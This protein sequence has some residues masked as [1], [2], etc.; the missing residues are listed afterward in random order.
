MF[1]FPN[2]SRLSWG[3]ITMRYSISSS[4]T[5]ISRFRILGVTLIVVLLMVSWKVSAEIIWAPTEAWTKAIQAYDQ[6][7]NSSVPKDIKE[8]LTNQFQEFEAFEQSMKDGTCPLCLESKSLDDEIKIH[9]DEVSNW[10]SQ[11][12]NFNASC[13]IVSSEEELAACR[14][15]RSELVNW[16]DRLNTEKQELDRR[17]AEIEEKLRISNET[18]DAKYLQ[19]AENVQEEFSKFSEKAYLLVNALDQAGKFVIE[20]YPNDE[21]HRC[22]LFFHKVLE[23]RGATEPG[24]K[25]DAAA[26]IY[27]ALT[28]NQSSDWETMGEDEVQEAANRGEIVVGV[29]SGHVAIAAPVPLSTDFSKFGGHSGPDIMV[30]DGNR[31]T[32]TS[33]QG[34]KGYKY[35]K[36]LGTVKV[37]YAFRNETPKWFIYVGSLK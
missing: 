13:A 37:A 26:A 4:R 9:E 12:A 10:D 30:R 23:L 20:Q 19:Y 18:K 32:G 3:R 16:Q 35:M 2:L 29:T 6:L 24:S 15:R 28:N 34:V 5:A 27:S 33:E 21:K 22:N 17:V 31:T 25:S 14:A 7:K 1:Y 11:V 36:D 8:E